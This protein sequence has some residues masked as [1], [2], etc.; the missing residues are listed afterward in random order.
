[1]VDI[2]GL[3]CCDAGGGGCKHR[4]GKPVVVPQACS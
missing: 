4:Q 1:M 2:S 3:V